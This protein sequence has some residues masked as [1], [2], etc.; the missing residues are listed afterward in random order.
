MHAQSSN[1]KEKTAY[2]HTEE[3]VFCADKIGALLY[4]QGY[5][6][7]RLYFELFFQRDGNPRINILLPITAPP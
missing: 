4:Q 5:Q 6:M 3:S 7:N 1:S 2:V